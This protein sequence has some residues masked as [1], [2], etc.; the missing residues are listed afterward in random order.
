MDP[1][2]ARDAYGPVCP[3]PV[4]LVTTSPGLRADRSGWPS[5]HRSNVPGRKFSTSTSA[6]ATR[7]RMICWPST[8]RRLQVTDFLLRAMIGQD[9]EKPCGR[10]LP[11]CRIGSPPRGSSTLITSAPKSP[12]S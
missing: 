8:V 1:N 7:S 12:S 6:V 3:Y 11:H 4:T 5:P 2:P 10:V 9:S